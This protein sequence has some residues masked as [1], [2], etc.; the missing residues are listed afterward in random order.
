MIQ[1]YVDD[2]FYCEK[3]ENV[4]DAPVS[5]IGGKIEIGVDLGVLLLTFYDLIEYGSG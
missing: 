4:P 2:E 1:R 3:I 5:R